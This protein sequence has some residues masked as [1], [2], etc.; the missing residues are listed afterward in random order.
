MWNV[1]K[2]EEKQKEVIGCPADCSG[3]TNSRKL[4]GGFKNRKMFPKKYKCT[5]IRKY[6][7]VFKQKFTPL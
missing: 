6:R 5:P 7:R 2:R 1:V 3:I 4:R